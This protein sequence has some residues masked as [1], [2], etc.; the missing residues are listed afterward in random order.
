MKTK[1]SYVQRSRILAPRQSA[2]ATN[3]EGYMVKVIINPGTGPVANTTEENAVI[4]IKQFVSDCESASGVTGLKWKRDPSSDDNGRYGFW[5]WKRLGWRNNA[6]HQIEMPGL[7]LEQ[8]RYVDSKTQN[9]WHFP[10][11][12]V[13]GSSWVWMY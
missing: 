9:I 12:Y 13:D 6:E 3:L 8:V 11:L 10:R 4:N 5:I 1:N 7:P 2:G